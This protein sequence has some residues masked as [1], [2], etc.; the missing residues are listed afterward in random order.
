MSKYDDTYQNE[1]VYF[2]QGGDKIAFDSDAYLAFYGNDTI[3]GE[4]L[5]TFLYTNQLYQVIAASGGAL[6]ITNL[7]SG[8]NVVLSLSNGCSNASA[9]LTS[10]LAGARLF[11]TI[12]RNGMGDAS[13][14]SVYISLSGVSLV[15]L[16]GQDLSSISLHNSGGSAGYIIFIAES[17]NEWAVVERNQGKVAERPSS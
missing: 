3:T 7:P 15:G 5:R 2:P 17:D 14:G 1:K 4:Q 6:S 12:R 13:I 9:W 10:C 16:S 8:G 11:L